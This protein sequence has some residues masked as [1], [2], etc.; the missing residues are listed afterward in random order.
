MQRL[1]KDRTLDWNLTHVYGNQDDST[2]WSNLSTLA[3]LNIEADNIAKTAVYISQKYK[4]RYQSYIPKSLPRVFM[5][6]DQTQPMSQ[7]AKVLSNYARQT[8]I[9]TYRI[10]KEQYSVKC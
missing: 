9:R 8:K 7:L 4:Y 3:Q 1:L 5:S 2:A 10:R 6:E